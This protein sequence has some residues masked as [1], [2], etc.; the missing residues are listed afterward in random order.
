MRFA[1]S[2]GAPLSEDIARTFIGLGLPI[3]QGYG[4][5]ETSPVISV[6]KLENNLPATV[7]EPVY[8]QEIRISDEDEL[9]VRGPN[10]MLGYWNNETATREIIDNEGWL[11]TGDKVTMVDG[12]IQITGRLK[13]IIV[14]SN[15]EKVPPAD[16]EMA[17]TNN[18]L[19]E[20]VMI[21][22]EGKPFLSAI[23]VLN[24]DRCKLLFG[25]KDIE[26]CLNTDESVQKILDQIKRQLISFPGYANIYK[27]FATLEPWTVESELIT[28]TL[29][30]KRNK[31]FEKYK[32]EIHKLYEGH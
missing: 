6:N 9:Q 30:L 3:A 27:V 23:V 18:S 12:H 1:I 28:P 29:K 7:G 22:G 4:L 15:G 10:V 25:E 26:S 24:A 20:Q 5:T 32:R 11:R 14:M 2:G 13:D 17:I 16:I 31:I 19:F 8:G 21:I